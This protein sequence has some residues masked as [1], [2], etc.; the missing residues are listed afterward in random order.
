[1]V[2]DLV[3]FLRARLDEEAEEARATTQGEWVWSREFVTPPGS[4][5]RTVGP[6]EPG[7]AWFIA[8]HSP[9]RVLAEVD[10]KRG[11]LDRYAEVA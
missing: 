11:L 3:A 9:A 1:D 7:D 8:R 6:L 2:D 10:A 4:H 5:H